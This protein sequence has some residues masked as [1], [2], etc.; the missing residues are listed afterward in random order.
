M[1]LS[2]ASEPRKLF[3]A[4]SQFSTVVSQLKQSTW[5]IKFCFPKFKSWRKTLK[6]YSTSV[7]DDD[8]MPCYRCFQG[9]SNHQEGQYGT[10]TCMRRFSCSRNWYQSSEKLNNKC[11]WEKITAKKN[12]HFCLPRNVFTKLLSKMQTNHS[13]KAFA[14]IISVYK[15][16]L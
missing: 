12:W 4:L 13:S 8:D 16:L 6:I 1:L 7:V 14:K 5:C 2:S 3:S 10:G 9:K 15:P 11:I